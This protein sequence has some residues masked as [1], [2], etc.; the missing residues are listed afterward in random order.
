MKKKQ[1]GIR[2][3]MKYAVLIFVALIA[4]FPIFWVISNSFKTLNGISQYPP[5]LFPD[6]LQYSNYSEAISKGNI[7]TYLKNTLILMLGNTLGTLISSSI[8]AYPLARMEFKGKNVVFGLILA[9]MM[10]PAIATIIP[11]FILFR[12]FGWIDSFKPMIVPAFFAYPYNVFLFRQF[13]KGLPRDLDEAAVID[14]CNK[15]QIFT[16]IL[17][18]LAKP[19]FI[20]VGVL[21]SVFWWNEMFQPLIYINTESLKPLTI[22]VLSAFKVQ[23]VNQWHLQMAFS[24]IMMIPPIILFTFAQ[25]YLVDGIKTSGLK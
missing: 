21:S 13:F 12:T 2:T 24:V 25:K 15:V 16:K 10:V 20:T 5:Q 14:G 9:T 1:S 7:L 8:V 3:C 23:F 17:A 11:Q 22:G 19:A 18:P 4:L 6:E